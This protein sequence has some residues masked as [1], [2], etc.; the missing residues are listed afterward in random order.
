MLCPLYD[1][2]KCAHAKRPALRLASVFPS[3][4]RGGMALTARDFSTPA[5]FVRVF[6]AFATTWLCL[7]AFTTLP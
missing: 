2:N 4:G 5:Q 7:C 1:S 6:G 3:G